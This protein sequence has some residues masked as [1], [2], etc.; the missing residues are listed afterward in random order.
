[1]NFWIVLALLFAAWL[2]L[3]YHFWRREQ[4]PKQPYDERQEQ[5]RGV[6]YKYGFLTLAV[7]VFLFDTVMTLFPWIGT[8]VGGYLCL[9]L[10]VTVFTVTAIRRDA[11]L[12]LYE[13]P[14]K[15]AALLA[16]GGLGGLGCGVFDL[17]KAGLLVDGTLNVS[18]ALVAVSVSVLLTLTVFLHK[19]FSDRREDE[20]A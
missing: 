12:R 16:L 11:Y 13:R 2:G 8:E 1:M 17:R 5:A 10:G 3:V 20:E 14:G 4:G 18:A 9:D 19:H 7:C 15:V 6:A